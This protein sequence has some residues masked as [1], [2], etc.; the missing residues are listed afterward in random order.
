MVRSVEHHGNGKRPAGLNPKE[1]GEMDA[2]DSN[3]ESRGQVTWNLIGHVSPNC[4]PWL[5]PS[6]QNGIINSF[7]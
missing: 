6:K 4:G 2:G 1:E 3:K 5:F 7:F